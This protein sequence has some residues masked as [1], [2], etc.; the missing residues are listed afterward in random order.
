MIVCRRHVPHPPIDAARLLPIDVRRLPIGVL[1]LFS[2]NLLRK[3]GEPL[4]FSS[5]ANTY[6]LVVSEGSTSL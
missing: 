6:R 4:S 5:H 1:L 3:S 2:Y